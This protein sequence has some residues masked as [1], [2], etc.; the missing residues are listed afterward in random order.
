M[1]QCGD[2]AVLL[3]WGLVVREEATAG[4]GGTH[5]VFAPAALLD[6]G[7]L[8]PEATGGTAGD[9]LWHGA[10]EPSEYDG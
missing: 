8:A 9:T 2:T 6:A 7:R 5:R 10:Y 1:P 3:D 4:G